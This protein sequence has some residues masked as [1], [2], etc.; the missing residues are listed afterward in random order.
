MKFGIEYRTLFG[1]NPFGHQRNGKQAGREGD[2]ARR[3]AQPGSQSGEA[4]RCCS[5]SSSSCA[6]SS[7]A[8]PSPSSAISARAASTSRRR[9][10]RPTS[11]AP[12]STRCASTAIPSW[13]KVGVP[14][15]GKC[16]GTLEALQG[17]R[18]GRDLPRAA[19]HQMAEGGD[20]RRHA[21]AD[22]HRRARRSRAAES[23]PGL[24]EAVLHAHG[25]STRT[26][27]R[28]ASPARPAPTSPIT[29]AN[30]R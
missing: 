19:V 24:K 18:H 12:T 16:K 13:T 25:G 26:P 5:A 22:D 11:S 21:R 2:V 23:P 4:A 28:C 9:S 17:R 14:T 3:G 20:G 27:K 8:R 30:I 15:I 29:A 1:F 10:P 6:G 7:R